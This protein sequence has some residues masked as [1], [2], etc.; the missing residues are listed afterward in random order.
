MNIYPHGDV[1]IDNDSTRHYY[2]II[3]QAQSQD[4]KKLTKR[5]VDY[6]YYER[7]HILPKSLF[8]EYIHEHWNLVLLTPQEHLLC[9]QLLIKMTKGKAYRSMLFAYWCMTVRVNKHM[10]RVIIS[11]TEYEKLRIE[12]SKA[13]QLGKK[14]CSES[15]KL[16]ISQANKGRKPAAN[17]IANSVNARK[18]KKK[19]ADAVR[20]SAEA[21][22]GNTNVRGKTWWNNGV[23]C[24]LAFTAPDA[25]WKKG[26][27]YSR[28]K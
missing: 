16:K 18:G 10:E 23:Q 9:H 6:R 5:N 12:F 13:Q 26:R 27:L 4:R 20:R 11:A 7:H 28:K 24:A 25:T 2:Q 17:T 21:Q 1:F 15:T 14:P 8:P 19:P 22:K 3:S